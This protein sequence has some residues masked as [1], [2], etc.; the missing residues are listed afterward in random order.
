MAKN[1][2]KARPIL[3]HD[4][5]ATISPPTRLHRRTFADNQ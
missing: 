5:V 1:Q 3:L 4:G 2:S